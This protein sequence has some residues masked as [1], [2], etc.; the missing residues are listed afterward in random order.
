[1]RQG[2]WYPQGKVWKGSGRDT[3]DGHFWPCAL[4]PE[5]MPL[6]SEAS[7]FQEWWGLQGLQ[8][9]HSSFDLNSSNAMKTSGPRVSCSCWLENSIKVYLFAL[10]TVN[11][12][13]FVFILPITKL[14]GCF[15]KSLCQREECEVIRLGLC[16]RAVGE[17][18]AKG[19]H[20]LGSFLVI[21]ED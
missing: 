16:S 15:I 21:K 7:L 12:T 8:T 10:C 3:W 17:Q 20:C 1:M 18:L 5:V 4:Q 14:L 9:L 2:L 19:Q 13:R 11:E 6:L